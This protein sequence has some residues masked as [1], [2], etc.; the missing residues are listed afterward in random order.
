MSRV[1]K[2][3]DGKLSRRNGLGK[4]LR[5][6]GLLQI[7]GNRLQIKRNR[8]RSTKGEVLAGAGW[9]LGGWGPAIELGRSAFGMNLKEQ[10][11]IKGLE[12]DKNL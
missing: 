12:V 9:L 10:R 4:A 11:G 8:V 5:C 2:P 6:H 1:T 3:K 7:K